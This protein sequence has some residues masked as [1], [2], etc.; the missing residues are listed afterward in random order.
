VVKCQTRKWGTFHLTNIQNSNDFKEQKMCIKGRAL[1]WAMESIGLSARFV[2]L[3]PN[4]PIES[5][6]YIKINMTTYL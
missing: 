5:S 4:P 3:L 2:L 6:S 1:P